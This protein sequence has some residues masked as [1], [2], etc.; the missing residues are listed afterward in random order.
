MNQDGNSS[1]ERHARQKP[2]DGAVPDREPG[3]LRG[4]SLA[5]ENDRIALSRMAI[6]D[7]Q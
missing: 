1:T 6:L 4:Q 7:C 2:G 3:W 5:V